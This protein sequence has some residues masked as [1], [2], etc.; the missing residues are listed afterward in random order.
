MAAFVTVCAAPSTSS[1][2]FS[3]EDFAWFTFGVTT[4]MIGGLQ[5]STAYV[6]GWSGLFHLFRVSKV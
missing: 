2:S 6:Q 1:F 4:T 5:T 3:K